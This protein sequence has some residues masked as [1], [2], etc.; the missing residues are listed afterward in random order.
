MKVLITGGTG[1]IG[2]YL[3]KELKNKGHNT[4]VLTNDPKARGRD[5]I[6]ANIIDRTKML[7]LIPKFDV[8]YHLAGLLGTSEL[9]EQAYQASRVNIL[10]TVN[11]LDAAR[12]NSTKV[13]FVTKPNCW[14]NTYSITK[15]AGESFTRMY[16]HELGLRT[17]GVRWFNVYGPGQSFH[18]QKAVPFFIKWA[19]TNQPVRVWGDGEQTMDLI[20][21][22]DAVTATIMVAENTRFEGSVVEVGSGLET[23]VN[24]LAELVIKKSFSKSKILHLPMRPGEIPNTKLK[25]NTK[26]LDSIGFKCKVSLDEGINETVKWYKETTLM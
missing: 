2:N 21:A 12:V 25:A 9:I 23:T 20:H 18:C 7:R 16:Y 26:V 3:A 4:S 19:L 24:K 6:K 13:I 5:L 10:G 17:V 1:F 8:I 11:I 15:F 22:K 14:L